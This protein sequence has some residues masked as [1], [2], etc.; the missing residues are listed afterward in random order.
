MISSLLLGNHPWQQLDCWRQ[1]FLLGLPQGYITRTPAKLQSV[2]SHSAEWS[3]WLVWNG[4]QPGTLLVELS[5]D[6][7]FSM[8]S[9]D[10]RTWVQEAEEFPSV[11]YCQ[12]MASGD[13]NRL[14]T[15][16]CQWS[17]KCSFECCIQ[18]VNKS[19]SPIHT[20]SIV[21]HTHTHLVE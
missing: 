12:E 21:T 10:K 9:C 4:C 16:V 15:L 2:V 5:V 3:R 17:V 11:I 14:R 1:C 20:P 7:E 19:N 18:V 8:G 13:C 6:K